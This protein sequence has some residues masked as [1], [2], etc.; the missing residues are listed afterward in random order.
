MT[1]D[2]VPN[3]KLDSAFHVNF[4]IYHEL[5]ASKV[6]RIL[7]VSS[8]Y[9]AFILEEDGSLAT[10]IITE[11]SGL[12]LS[13]PPRVTRIASAKKAL[14]IIREKVV[15]LVL[16]MPHLDNMDAFSFGAAVRALKPNLPV[17]LLAHSP[18]GIFPVPPGK[19]R[20]GIDRIAIWSGNSD[21]LLAI[22]KSVEDRMNVARDCQKAQVRVLLLVEDNPVYQSVLLP[23]VYKEVV[24]Q[25]QAILMDGLNEDHR[26]LKMRARPKILLA[27]TYDEAVTL[28]EHYKDYMFGVISDTR[29]PRQ[30]TMDPDAGWNFL[31]RVRAEIPD[32]PLLLLSSD[33]ENAKRAASVPAAF[34]DKNTP[35]LL[36]E[37]HGF[38]LSDLGFG[39]FVFRL[40]DGKEV[41]RASNL[42]QLQERIAEVPEG[43]L[44]YH[45]HRNH[46]SNWI[47]GRSEIALASS[48]RKVSADAFDDV[49]GMRRYLITNI[50]ALRRL[51]QKGVVAQFKSGAYDPSVMDFV[52]IGSGSLG[53]KA[54]SLA[55]MSAMLQDAMEL[56]QAYPTVEIQ[57]PRTL[58]LCTDGFEAFLS[59]NRME[60]LASTEDLGDNAVVAKRFLE[61][62]M[63]AHLV[64]QL[65]AFVKQVTFPLSVRSSS[66]L[67]DAQFQPYAG[68]Y[69]TYMIPNNHPDPVVRLRQLVSAV[70]LVYASTFYEDPRAFSR[71]LAALPQEEAMAVIIQELAGSRHGDYFYP[72][73]AGV[74][75][76]HN[77][78]PISPMTAD[79]GIALVALG[80]GRTVVQGERS[81][82]FSPKHPEVLPQ[83]SS[84]DDILE[85]AQRFF[86][87]LRVAD[88]PESLDHLTNANLD[89]RDIDDA[90]EEAP[91][92]ILASTYSI[93]EH[94][95]RDTFNGTGAAVIT[96]ASV[97]KYQRF[98]LASVLGDLLKIGRQG[99]G[100]PVEMEFAVAL[101]PAGSGKKD[102]FYFLQ[103]RPMATGGERF[104]V[105]ISA[106][107]VNHA[108]CRSASALGNGRIDDIRDVVYVRPD[109]FEAAATP[110]MAEAVGR[111]N[112]VLSA[113]KRPYLL[114]GPGRW[115]SA[116]R[117]LGIPVQWH[118]IS[119]V[120]AIVEVRNDLLHADPSQGS[121]FFQNITAL[122]IPYLTV[123]EGTDGCIDW[124]WLDGLPAVSASQFV[125]HVRLDAPVVV[126]INGQT[127]QGVI[128]S[129]GFDEI[130]RG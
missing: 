51:R 127:G 125:R 99:M 96:F 21:L 118:Q 66:L 26:L 41:A 27:E 104:D 57:V 33:P 92:K 13:H 83:F 23:L 64:T 28:Y 80:M 25:T 30:G 10:R 31:A 2:T 49:D 65:S 122:G 130:G 72:T 12:N 35:H 11:Y 87:A 24:R 6:R 18:R 94:R 113:Q 121:H 22:V 47:M 40:P 103:M 20:N 105:E 54:R 82:R 62:Q 78:Y 115:G 3:A 98:P 73:F 85:N 38:F 120:G 108:L 97:L 117:W 101:A 60:D 107:E 53:G 15:D 7:L 71:H 114:V 102:G 129:A 1:T 100:C 4:K 9:D 93:D 110:K 90:A 46:F 128:L 17:I 74:A 56:H 50:Q 84:V 70:K 123:T 8:P 77:Y 19:H 16:T 43:C 76:S 106:E 68:L 67:E 42:R 95:I 45:A 124:S 69:E 126:K 55:F 79:D 32:L 112:A 111:C 29:M 86:Y 58:V 88:C 116:D 52:R 63:P 61:A 34:L 59:H 75:Q 5:M 36:K 109:A 81:L 44:R 37:I 14:E 91:V 39:D 89:R 48:F 119:N